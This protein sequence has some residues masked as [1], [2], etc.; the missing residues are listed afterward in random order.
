[1]PPAYVAVDLL[2][3]DYVQRVL[4]AAFDLLTEVEQSDQ[5]LLPDSVVASAEAFRKLLEARP[6]C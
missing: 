3:V 2:N 6:G 5:V 1:M 4:L